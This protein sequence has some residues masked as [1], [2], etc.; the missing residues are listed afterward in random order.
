[1]NYILVIHRD[2]YTGV[3]TTMRPKATQ[4]LAS[5]VQV[6]NYG[7]IKNYSRIS[8]SRPHKLVLTSTI[9]NLLNIRLKNHV[10]VALLGYQQP[11]Q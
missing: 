5:V 3:D 4:Q 8:L 6:D 10:E 2:D 11:D 7:I 9:P 1:M